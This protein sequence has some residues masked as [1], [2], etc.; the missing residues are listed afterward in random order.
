MVQ[1]EFLTLDKV[2][3]SKSEH[4]PFVILARFDQYLGKS[5]R[6]R[7]SETRK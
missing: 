4:D 5:E 1:V 6:E 3:F 2:T 7:E